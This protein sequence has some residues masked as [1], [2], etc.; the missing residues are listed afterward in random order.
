LALKA[1]VLRIHTDEDL[2]TILMGFNPVGAGERHTV[3]DQ[4]TALIT[5]LGP[6]GNTL[7]RDLENLADTLVED[8]PEPTKA[9][10][11][12]IS[13]WEEPVDHRVETQPAK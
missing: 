6:E 3:E 9:I 8:S 13:L 7:K 10:E 12:F 1:I 11:N 2:E 4:V 5:A